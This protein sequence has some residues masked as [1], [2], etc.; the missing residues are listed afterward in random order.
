MKTVSF[1]ENTNEHRKIGKF[2]K[3]ALTD[4]KINKHKTK[5][6]QE[7]EKHG[8]RHVRE[9]QKKKKKKRCSSQW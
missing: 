7:Q 9:D 6:E 8:E 1:S 2:G 5:Q 3:S 4:V